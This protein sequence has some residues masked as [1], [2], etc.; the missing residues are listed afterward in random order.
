MRSS[1][2]SSTFLRRVS[3]VLA[4]APITCAPTMSGSDIARLMSREAVGSVVVIANGRPVGI[5]TDRD[6]RRKIVGEARDARTT[7]ASDL[8]SSPLIAIAASALVLDALVTMT[9]HG[10]HHLPVMSDGALAGVVSASDV[11]R[12]HLL[13]PV[14][15]ARSIASAPSLEILR[16]AADQVTQVVR[17]L[18]SAGA[19][20]YDVGALVA[21]LNDQLVQRVLA[22]TEASVAARGER[23]PVPY[24]WLAFGS[25]ARREQT[26]RTDQDN[27]LVYA[28]P[29]PD[30]A[31]AAAAYYKNFAETAVHGLVAIGFPPCPGG[32]MASNPA[33]CRPLGG[34]LASFARWL[35]HPSPAEILAASIH[36]D[37]RPTSGALG[38]GDDLAAFI[39]REAPK[40]R[41]FLGMLARDV[42]SHRPQ[43]TLFGRV[44][45]RG[46][47]LDVKGAATMPLAGT[48]R[49]DALELG[50]AEVNTVERFR[51]AG[52]RGLYTATETTDIVE[53]YQHVL[54]LRLVHQLGQLDAGSA[55]DNRVEYRRLSRAD[56]LLLREALR[57]VRRVQAGLRQRFRT[58]LLG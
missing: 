15:L 30:Q 57:T 50:L 24:C 13:H 54:R 6:L 5:V 52:A 9:R 3:D 14:A 40:R 8:M 38:L 7:V 56:A 27:G 48:A 49:V 47:G 2:D 32:T 46:G 42:V 31:A 53:A 43:L 11:L 17:R 19:S 23:P 34:W 1:D 29:A 41:T 16:S 21:E 22:L 25:E 4:R 55:P 39:A 44:A 51:A 28:E 20:G 36:F 35:D 37:M 33:L 10:I 45:T 12:L 18:V 26:L 58:D